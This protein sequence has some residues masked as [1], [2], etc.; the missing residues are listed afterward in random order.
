MPGSHTPAS[1]A[2]VIPIV[3]N[4]TQ[5]QFACSI[6]NVPTSCT[7]DTGARGAISL[8]TPFIESHPGVVPARLTAPGVNG[9]GVGGPNV[10]RLGRVRTLSFGSLTLRDLVGDYATQSKGGLAMPFI[11]AN[12]GGAVWKRFTMTLDYGH[13]TMAL[14]PNAEVSVR[15]HWDRSGLFLI[16]NGA[17]T[18]ID[19]RPGTPGADA[20]VDKGDAIVSVNGS[21]GLSLSQVR[22]L[23][24]AEPGTIE[25]LVIKSKDGAIHNVELTLED[26]V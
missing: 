17:I 9:F 10:G 2:T 5:P 26:Y 21:S 8:F 1:D 22:E 16:N 4:G 23:L 14:T 3:L 20:G 18:I 11:G 6:D 24:S 25:H 13:L 12:V 19:V 7:L 15:D